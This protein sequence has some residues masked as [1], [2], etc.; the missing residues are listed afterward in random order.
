MASEDCPFFLF[1][2]MVNLHYPTLPHPDFDGISGFGGNADCMMELDCRT[3][4]IIDKLDELGLQDDTI[5]IFCS[6]NGPE[7]RNPWRGTAGP[8]R[9]TYHTAMEGSLRV[10]FIVRWPGRVEKGTTSNEIVHVT[11]LYATLA[12]IAGAELPNDRPVDGIDQCDFLFG[13]SGKSKREGF[14]FFIKQE[15]RAVKWRDWKLHYYWEPEVNESKGKLE[16]P[17]LFNITVDPKEEHDIATANS[18]AWVAMSRLVD[19][20]NA[21]MKDYPNTE[22]G[23]DGPPGMN[24]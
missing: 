15:L 19:E 1:L 20:F 13:G 10:P 23:A 9:G 18:W 2:P 12:S 11:D 3:G 21:S 4:E 5:L 14:P 22:P 24:R 16:S 6:D 17:Y 8:W 7:F